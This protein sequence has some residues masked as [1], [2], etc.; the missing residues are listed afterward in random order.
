MKSLWDFPSRT[1]AIEELGV[2]GF[3]A[4]AIGGRRPE[5]GPLSPARPREGEHL[6][7]RENL[8]RS[9]KCRS[10]RGIAFA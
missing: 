8:D 3:V 9:P 2:E 10:A 1:A 6:S 4:A 7:V 5:T